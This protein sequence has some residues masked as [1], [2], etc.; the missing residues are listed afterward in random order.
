MTAAKRLTDSE[1]TYLDSMVS[2]EEIKNAVWDCGSQKA[3]GPDGF[4]FMFIKKYWDLLHLDI[5]NF[6]D[7]FFSTRTFPPG[8]NS[9]FFTLIPKVSNPLYIKDYRPISLI[10][11]QYKIVAKILANRLSKAFD[12]VSWSFLDHVMDNLGFSSKWRRWIKSGLVSSRA[13]ILV[14]GS[15]TSEFS[16]KRGLRQGDP[17]SPFL[18]II[19]MEGLHIAFKDGLSSNMF[20]GVNVGSPGI[21]LSHLFYADDVI[22]FSD[23]NQ[24][25]MDNIIHIL[26]IFYLASGLRI[27]INKSNLYGVGVSHSEVE[28]MAA[29]FGCSPSYLPF[30]YF[31]L[32]IGSN[33]SH[34]SNWKVLIDRFKS[35]LLGWKAILLSSG[36]RLTVIKSVLGSLSIYFLSIFKAPEAVIK[37]G[38]EFMHDTDWALSSVPALVLDEECVV[39]RD[40]SNCDMGRVK[41]F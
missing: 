27:N 9:S 20:R 22:I 39:E 37:I 21:R 15:P 41:S 19:I 36:D 30:S 8:A 11:F 35:R 2:L 13:S 5:Q 6:V 32:P 26:N 33:M 3:R 40:F 23:W 38:G 12:S 28:T 14:N 18:F 17:L 24:H 1:V 10:G 34:I 4:S 25:H 29:G 16:L 7:S 31:G